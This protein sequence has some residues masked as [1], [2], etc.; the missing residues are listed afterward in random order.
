MTISSSG[1]SR[2]S[3]LFRNLE[4]AAS[5][6]ERILKKSFMCAQQP[7]LRHGPLSGYK[8]LGVY[9]PPPTITLMPSLNC[10]WN[11][12]VTKLKGIVYPKMTILL[13]FCRIL[14]KIFWKICCFNW[15]IN[16]HWMFFERFHRRKSV[17]S[18]LEE[19]EGEQMI[20]LV[21]V[22]RN[23]LPI[24]KNLHKI[25][26]KNHTDQQLPSLLHLL[27]MLK[28]WTQKSRHFIRVGVTF[29]FDTTGE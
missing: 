8:A 25:R 27:T 29:W 24:L 4:K 16:S 17:R 21:D 19:N 13:S 11:V 18:G 12:P 5:E 20:K 2:I 7:L 26:C 15:I 3:V 10:G 1:T 23:K 28:C 6:G 14:K 9:E 22:M